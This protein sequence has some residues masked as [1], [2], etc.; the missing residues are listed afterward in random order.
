MSRDVSG[1]RHRGPEDV[2]IKVIDRVSR[3]ESVL[4][5][6]EGPWPIG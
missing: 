4:R 5:D 3:G 6:K 2:A 1:P